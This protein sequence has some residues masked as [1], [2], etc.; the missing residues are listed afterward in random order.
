MAYTTKVLSG[1]TYWYKD[2]KRIAASKVPASAKKG[3]RANGKKPNGKK[4]NGNGTDYGKQLRRVQK[5]CRKRSDVSKGDLIDALRTLTKDE[6]CK[7][8]A[9]VP[10]TPKA[11]TERMQK[12]S[13]CLFG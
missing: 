10:S 2:G 12:K 6:L 11:T 8:I 3:G 13:G 5:K 1:R 9:Q 7:L 4:P